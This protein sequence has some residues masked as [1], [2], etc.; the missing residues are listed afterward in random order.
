[1]KKALVGIIAAFAILPLS[2]ANSLPSCP[3]KRSRWTT[4]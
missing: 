3:T 4:A 1:M 2:A